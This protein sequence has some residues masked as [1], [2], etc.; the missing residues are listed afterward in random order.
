[1]TT[2]KK[3]NKNIYRAAFLPFRNEVVFL[4]I[5]F[6]ISALTS[7]RPKFYEAPTPG[8]AGAGSVNFNKYVAVGQTTES[9]YAD[10]AL[11]TEAQNNSYP[12]LIAQKI[13]EVNPSLQW[14][15][16]DINSVNGWQFSKSGKNG[17]YFLASSTCTSITFPRDTAVGD[18]TI[19]SF[20]GNQA[21]I[22]NLSVPFLL[23][24]NFNTA[25][26]PAGT[27]STNPAPYY[28]RIVNAGTTKGIAS[29]AKQ[30]NASF[31]TV[32]VG[33]ED[34][35]KAAK[36]G[37]V[38]SMVSVSTF[39]QGVQDILDSLLDVPGSKGVIATIPYVDLIPVITNNNRRLTS[40]SDPA[41]NPVRFPSQTY[42]DSLSIL[43]TGSTGLFSG[44][45]GNKNNYAI[46][47]GA[48]TIRQLSTSKDFILRSNLLDSVG[49]GKIDPNATRTC[50]PNNNPR[51]GK[52]FNAAIA[53]A[54]VLDQTEITTLRAQIDAYNNAIKT[55]V[56]ARNTN[57]VR[58]AIVDL[59]AF[60]TTLTDP[61]YGIQYG[62]SIIRANHPSLGPDF[63]GFYSLDRTYPTPKGQS[64]LANEFIKVINATWGASLHL[65]NPD[66]FRANII[67]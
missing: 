16:A 34:A 20:S 10:N 65:Y 58:V 12:N 45:T 15:Q 25:T 31:F 44:A 67:P 4:V 52:G 64:L 37:V 41:K 38:T 14:F 35:L 57:G 48:G 5:L 46:K 30:R 1:M 36:S 19:N 50:T 61:L 6:V 28:N 51:T 49:F 21:D 18:A 56:A 24:T 13:K 54:D 53:D 22:T 9:G 23:T 17:R 43:V 27:K 59:N 32:S 62:S 63:G 7:C 2:M 47:T 33:F 55:L 66:D 11:Y 39:Q 26:V 40:S 3:I 29:E 42:A 60:Y 8:A